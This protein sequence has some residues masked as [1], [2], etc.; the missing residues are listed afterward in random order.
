MTCAQNR[1]LEGMLA[2][3]DQILTETELY[4]LTLEDHYS[5]KVPGFS[6]LTVKLRRARVQIVAGDG[7]AKLVQCLVNNDIA[8]K[9]HPPTTIRPI[10]SCCI[11]V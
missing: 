7:S 11:K 5:Y 8:S 6:V 1:N 9:L 3:S 10:D 4:V 2:S